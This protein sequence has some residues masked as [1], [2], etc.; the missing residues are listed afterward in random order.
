LLTIKSN[1]E[2][3]KNKTNIKNVFFVKGEWSGKISRRGHG[4]RKG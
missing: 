2:K 3:Y 1:L 4:D